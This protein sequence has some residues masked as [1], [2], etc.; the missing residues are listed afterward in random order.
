MEGCRRLTDLLAIP[1][2]ELFL[3]GFNH[4]S[5]GAGSPR[6]SGLCPRPVCLARL[7]LITDSTT[8]GLTLPKGSS[9]GRERRQMRHTAWR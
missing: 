7:R 1:A 4:L 3:Y 8:V 5:I 9:P 6:G 2:G